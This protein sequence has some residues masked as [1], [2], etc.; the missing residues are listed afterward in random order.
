MW[1]N[2][3]RDVMVALPNIG[4]VLIRPMEGINTVSLQTL[5]ALKRAGYAVWQLERRA[6]NVTANVRS[7]HHLQILL[8]QFFLHFFSTF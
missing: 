4:A 6:S 7:D 3:Q 1:A 8:L 2:T 5:V